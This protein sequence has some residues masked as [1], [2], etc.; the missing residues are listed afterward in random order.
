M[1]NRDDWERG[2]N[3]QAERNWEMED[4][5][6]AG[7][8]G[9]YASPSS[10]E[11]RDRWRSPERY[12]RSGVYGR[13]WGGRDWEPEDDRFR[14]YDTRASMREHRGGLVEP[15]WDWYPPERRGSLSDPFRARL[16]VDEGFGG[17][18]PA[19]V[20]E[21]WSAR[22]ALHHRLSPSGFSR[23][24][25][26]SEWRQG[27]HTGR[28]PK[29]WR[30]SDERIL[31]NVNEALARHPDLDASGIEVRA[32]KGEVTLTG[33]VEDRG[34]K[35]LAED[36]AEEVFGVEDVHNELKIRRGAFATLTGEKADRA[37]EREAQQSATTPSRA[38]TKARTRS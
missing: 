19:T 17:Y 9:R 3:R 4:R 10:E 30:R 37:D 35:R 5:D 23:E 2:R 18:G 29:G 16:A 15:N 28:G 34:D 31:D 14:D 33:V 24:W 8:S 7:F 26:S 32:L 12:G 1:P 25:G 11:R 21:G 6:D 27:P 22:R 20:R 36:I 13:G 38:G